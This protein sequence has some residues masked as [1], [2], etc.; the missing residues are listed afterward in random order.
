MASDKIKDFS[1]RLSG[2]GKGSQELVPAATVVLLRPAADGFETLMLR[3]NSKLAF[4]GM[5]VFPGGK[6]DPEDGHEGLPMEDRARF[7]AVREASEEAQLELQPQA[8]HWFAH[9]TPPPLGNRRFLTWFFVTT[10]PASEVVID[11]D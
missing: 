11:D 6:I 7:A 4:G 1:K 5:W 9:W 10:A 3:K 2:G 8:L